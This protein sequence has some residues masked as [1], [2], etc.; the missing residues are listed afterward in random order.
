[1]S[2]PQNELRA[3]SFTDVRNGQ[4]AFLRIYVPAKQMVYPGRTGSRIV[5]ITGKAK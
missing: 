2:N 1:M 4:F 3:A 5:E